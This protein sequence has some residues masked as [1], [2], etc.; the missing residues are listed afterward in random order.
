MVS[1]Q[2][3][4]PIKRDRN[5]TLG[6]KLRYCTELRV[7][8][9]LFAPIKRDKVEHFAHPSEHQEFPFNCLPLLKE[10]TTQPTTT[11]TTDPGFPFNCLPLLKE[12]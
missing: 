12:T 1:I 11:T 5:V 10:T 2:L 3:F 4:A 7:S 6:E 8:I 9:Q